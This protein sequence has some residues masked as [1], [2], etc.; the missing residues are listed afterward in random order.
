MKTKRSF[1]FSRSSSR[2]NSYWFDH[3]ERRRH[4]HL[5]L[6]VVF[7]DVKELITRLTKIL[8]MELFSFLRTHRDRR[9][10]FEPPKTNKK[11]HTQHIHILILILILIIIKTHI[12][13]GRRIANEENANEKAKPTK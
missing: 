7:C 8:K 5:L 6:R 1:S 10:R 4:H 2:R 3:H 12:N 11:Q 9:E 13:N